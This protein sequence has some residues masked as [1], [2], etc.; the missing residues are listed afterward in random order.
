MQSLSLTALSVPLSSVVSEQ[1]ATA[2]PQAGPE[3]SEGQSDPGSPAGPL[4]QR[5]A[6]LLHHQHGPGQWLRLG[7]PLD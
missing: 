6:T 5:L 2:G 1:R 3:G 4:L 7:E